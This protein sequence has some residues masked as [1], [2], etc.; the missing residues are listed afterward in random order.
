MFRQRVRILV[1]RST[2]FAENTN[3]GVHVACLQSTD[4]LAREGAQERLNMCLHILE[5]VRPSAW[6]TRNNQ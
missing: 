2:L 4:K 3:R 5:R 6:L 1:E